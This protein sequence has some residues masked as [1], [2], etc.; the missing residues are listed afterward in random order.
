M[1]EG[2]KLIKRIEWMKVNWEKNK[3][4]EWMWRKGYNKR[5][6]ANKGI[7]WMKERKR[8]KENDRLNEGMNVKKE[9]EWMKGN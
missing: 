1:N 5:K 4:N 8:K 2:W 6:T 9:T 3:M 7:E